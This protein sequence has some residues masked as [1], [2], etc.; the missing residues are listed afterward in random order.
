MDQYDEVALQI[1][2]AIKENVSEN[3]F[4]DK[5]QQKITDVLKNNFNIKDEEM[6][7]S[8]MTYVGM[9]DPDSGYVFDTPLFTAPMFITTGAMTIGPETFPNY[10]IENKYI[11]YTSKERFYQINDFTRF[12]RH[13]RKQPLTVIAL[14]VLTFLIVSV[15]TDVIFRSGM[16][17]SPCCRI[18]I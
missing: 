8:L 1:V 13:M 7:R 2:D 10:S 18:S 11:G 6:G 14:F 5:T 9:F 12:M 4:D 3:K 15:L 17:G 16:Q